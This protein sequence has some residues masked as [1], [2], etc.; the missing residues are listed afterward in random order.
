[1][2]P[3]LTP[4]F[5]N[6]RQVIVGKDEV[7]CLVLTAL[8]ARGH[9][10]IEDLPGVG[11]T[12]LA[13]ALARSLGGLFKRLQFTPDLLP[14]DVTG[15]S[16]YRPSS[17]EFEFVAGPV[18]AHVLLADELNR[19]SPRTQSSLLEAM[20]EGQVSVDGQALELPE[21]FFVI[22]T[23][24]P[25]E[26]AGTFPLPEAQ[27]DRFMMRLEMGYPGPAEEAEMLA[28]RVRVQ[29]LSTLSPVMDTDAVMRL[30]AQVREVQ[31][32]RAVND[33]IVALS[34]ATRN[35]PDVRIG[36]SPRGSLA[37]MCAAQAYAFVAQEPFVTP[38][39][40]KA[41]A[42]PVLAHRIHLD[43]HREYAGVASADLLAQ[44]LEQVP[45]PVAPS[46]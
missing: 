6:V 38:D 26:M 16:V 20:A 17:E 43:Q 33:Y 3:E 36:V 14:T 32:S 31:V 2:H 27:L 13:R 37:L 42:G 15:V 7:I 22:A 28:S 29:P 40:V 30:Q 21:P 9:V 25:I 23:Q 46:A 34:T 41:V 44:V 39:A 1:M 4:L 45:V 18:F 19:T 5:D 11:K 35:H 10:L 12:M 8:L 24:N